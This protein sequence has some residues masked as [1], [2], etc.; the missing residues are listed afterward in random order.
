M[1]LGKRP[2]FAGGLVR[3]AVARQ[4]VSG[5]R[6]EFRYPAAVFVSWHWLEAE[7][8]CGAIGV[9]GSRTGSPGGQSAMGSLPGFLAAAFLTPDLIGDSSHAV[10]RTSICRG[11]VCAIFRL[12]HWTARRDM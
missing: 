11:K 8:V 10:H 4:H 5:W 3:A 2:G 1:G 6:N 7:R 9:V 12:C